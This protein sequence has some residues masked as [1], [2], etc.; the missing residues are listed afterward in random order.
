MTNWKKRWCRQRKGQVVPSFLCAGQ[1]VLKPACSIKATYCTSEGRA[2][3]PGFTAEKPNLRADKAL[4]QYAKGMAMTPLRTSIF[5]LFLSLS[6][7]R[8]WVHLS[9]IGHHATTPSRTPFTH[10]VRSNNLKP[11]LPAGFRDINSLLSLSIY[12]YICVV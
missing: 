9:G 4:V 3:M 11:C 6:P 5:R 7:T 1:R 8:L 12:I 10:F 2:A